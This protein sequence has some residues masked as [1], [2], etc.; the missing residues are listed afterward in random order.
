MSKATLVLEI[1]KPHFTVKLYENLLNIDLKGGI[2]NEIEEAL[3]NKPILRE[4][5]GAILSI[6]APLHVRLCDIDSVYAEKTGK[7]K[8]VLPHRRDVDI[9]LE[10]KEAKRLVSKLNQL[11][12]KE[13]K[14]ELDRVIRENRLKR[15]AGEE[16]KMARS[17]AVASSGF[18]LPQPPGILHQIKE[19]KEK[20][21]K[22]ET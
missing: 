18:P 5:I 3:E 20:L 13:K 12:P 9:P 17:S 1:D 14:K 7:V 16:E 2:K 15:I 21:E 11:I 6:F 8:I 4:T 22:E 10:L 19:S